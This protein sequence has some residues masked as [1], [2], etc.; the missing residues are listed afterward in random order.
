ML[1][2]S[3]LQLEICNGNQ[4][5]TIT[6]LRISSEEKNRLASARSFHALELLIFELFIATKLKYNAKT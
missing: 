5:L 3:G 2:W 1:V 6:Y 4:V